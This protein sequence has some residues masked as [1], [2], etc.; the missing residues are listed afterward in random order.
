MNIYDLKNKDLIK[1]NNEFKKTAFG[2]R[3]KFFSISTLIALIITLMAI[4]VYA[5]IQEDV[6]AVV[7]LGYQVIPG[8]IGLTCIAQLQYGRMLR[9]YYE[10]KKN[11]K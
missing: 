5:S 6:K 8:V 11:N 3:A 2:A 10:A 4:L 1:V 9:E 7:S